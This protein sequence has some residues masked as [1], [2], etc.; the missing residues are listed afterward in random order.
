MAQCAHTDPPDVMR[1][2]ETWL[3]EQGLSDQ[4]WPGVVVRHAENTPGAMW[5]SIVIEIERRGEGWVV[6]KLDR[7]KLPLDE[8]EGLSLV[9]ARV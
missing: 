5:E 7:R 4:S 8:P 1:K 9:Q 3:R 2:A 6:T